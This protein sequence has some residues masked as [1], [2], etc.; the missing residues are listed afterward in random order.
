M[1]E[2]FGR[3]IKTDNFADLHVHT[4]QSPDGRMTPA[5]V[6]Q[7]A[8]QTYLTA[9]AITDH[10]KIGPAYEAADY[11]ER[12]GVDI[13]VVIGS[14]IS[15]ADGHVIG[16]FL[17]GDIPKGTSVEKAIYQIHRQQ[18]LA[19]AAHP[20]FRISRSLKES[21]IMRVVENGDEEVY[22]DGFEVFNMG[23]EDI[24]LR[25]GKKYENSNRK[26]QQFFLSSPIPGA[27]IASSDAHRYTVARASTGYTG[28]LYRAIKERKTLAVVLD[29]IEQR[30]IF[31][32]AVEMFGRER[33]LGK[34]PIEEF[35]QRFLAQSE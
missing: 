15:T 34:I 28:N 9:L 26:A 21:A 5:Q 3:P 10:D 16:I 29:P 6:V 14:E 20:F 4:N 27:A 31:L 22:F 1:K 13:E 11:R 7:L 33:V 30:N 2:V 23:A 19:I 24:H 35:E 25:R 8:E 17:T 12:K 32:K 18:G